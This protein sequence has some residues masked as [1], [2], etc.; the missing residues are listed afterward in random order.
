MNPAEFFPESNSSLPEHPQN[1]TGRPPKVGDPSA[2]PRAGPFRFAWSFACKNISFTSKS[3]EASRNSVASAG[4]VAAP[5]H[6]SRIL[7]RVAFEYEVIEST[8]M[9]H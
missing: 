5:N 3:V 2:L 6:G 8:E 9:C 1:P 7:E 4:E